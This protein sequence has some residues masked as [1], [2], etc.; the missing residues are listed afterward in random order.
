[1]DTFCGSHVPPPDIPVIV[2]LNPD[3]FA[4]I[5]FVI[6]FHSHPIVEP[7]GLVTTMTSSPA[8]S[9]GNVTR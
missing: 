7:D 6:K 3:L 1:M 9:F 5:T 2:T 4:E 8:N